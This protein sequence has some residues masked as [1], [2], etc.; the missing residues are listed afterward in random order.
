MLPIRGK[1]HAGKL[2]ATVS[3]VSKEKDLNNAKGSN[4]IFHVRNTDIRIR[5]AII[6][7]I[8]L[9]LFFSVLSSYL[10][11]SFTLQGLE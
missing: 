9:A 11:C 5:M 1:S 6:I 10:N 8:N 2:M 7:T 3:S 4:I